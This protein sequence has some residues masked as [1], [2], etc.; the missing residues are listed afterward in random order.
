M[1]TVWLISETKPAP[2]SIKACVVMPAHSI[3][4]VGDQFPALIPSNGSDKMLREFPEWPVL[5]A[6]LMLA[7]LFAGLM[8]HTIRF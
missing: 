7:F 2:V 6:M 4:R 8:V 1:I 3:G 5:V